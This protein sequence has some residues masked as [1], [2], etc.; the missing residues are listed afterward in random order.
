MT[1]TITFLGHAT[2]QI[3]TAGQTIL[4]DPFLPDNPAASTTADAVT[5]D[6]IVNINQNGPGNA[7]VPNTKPNTASS[8][9]GLR[10]AHAS[11]KRDVR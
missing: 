7:T 10:K 2:L 9:R 4:V 11:P 3:T 8:K 1:T 6:V 5:P